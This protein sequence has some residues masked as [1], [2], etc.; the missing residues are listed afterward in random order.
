MSPMTYI[1]RSDIFLYLHFPKIAYTLRHLPNQRRIST[2]RCFSLI[3]NVIGKN[4]WMEALRLRIIARQ[5]WFRHSM[6]LVPI[7]KNKTNEVS[8][9]S[10]VLVLT[11]SLE[12]V[13]SSMSYRYIYSLCKSA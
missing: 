10:T 1:W 2:F 9:V 5:N 12:I 3:K 11:F 8:H 7:T 4:R 13:L 6:F